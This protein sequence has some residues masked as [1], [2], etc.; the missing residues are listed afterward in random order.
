MKKSI[1]FSLAL[2]A[3][4]ASLMT[5]AAPVKSRLASFSTDYQSA[6]EPERIRWV[7][8]EKYN[9]RGIIVQDERFSRIDNF[10]PVTGGHTITWR[11]GKRL[12]D[13]SSI[14]LYTADLKYIDY[15]AAAFTGGQRTITLPAN[16]AYVRFSAYTESKDITFL[17]DDTT[18][19]YIVRDGEIVEKEGELE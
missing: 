8:G 15:Y 17:R 19:E 14:I 10:L 6:E 4:A 12:G 11:W 18:G 13:T 7:D 1:I 16:T 3:T 5:L 2:A 9:N